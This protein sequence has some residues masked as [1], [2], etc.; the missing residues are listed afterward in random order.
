M[1]AEYY[2]D[3]VGV[4]EGTDKSSSNYAAWDYLS[5][6]QTLFAHL[7]DERFNLIEIGVGGGNSLKVWKS[8]FPH[9]SI[10]GVDILPDR[11]RHAEERVKIEIGSQDDPEFLARICAA[12]P[13]TIIIDDGSHLAH[14]IIYTFERMFPSLL[15]GGFYV[16][17]DLK[18]HFGEHAQRQRMPNCESPLDYFGEIIKSRMAK[19]PPAHPNNWGMQKYV[20]DNTDAITAID[21]AVIFQ[22]RKAKIAIEAAEKFAAAYLAANPFDARA[23]QRLTEYYLRHWG[24]TEQAERA[25]RKALELRPNDPTAAKRLAEVLVDQGRIDEAVGVAAS[26]TERAGA[27]ADLWACL[28][29]IHVKRKDYPAAAAALSKAVEIDP[30][31]PVFHFELG[32]AFERLGRNEDALEH[33][34]AAAKLTAGTPQEAAYAKHFGAVRART[35]VAG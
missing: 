24:A 31:S 19:M 14:H 21:S 18:F 13:P 7:R 22:K 34:A 15:P 10:V 23:Y 30:A 25:A 20:F 12:N 6:Y 3:I 35:G 29:R 1:S 5:K 11:T 8:F 32:F 33:A 17:E 26:G 27:N 4:L 16:V 2:L 9:A 28:G